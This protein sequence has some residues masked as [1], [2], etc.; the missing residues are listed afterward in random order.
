ML[1]CDVGSE[2]VHDVGHEVVYN[3]ESDIMDEVEMEQCYRSIVTS[4]E[5]TSEHGITDSERQVC[6]VEG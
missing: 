2:I 6:R 1:E 3:G 5:A 4:Q